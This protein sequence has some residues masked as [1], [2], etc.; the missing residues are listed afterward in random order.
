MVLKVVC[1]RCGEQFRLADSK[2]GKRF[3]CHDCG[4]VVEVPSE[5]AESITPLD[6]P[7][8]SV[9]PTV[10]PSPVIDVPL[11]PEKKKNSA[12]IWAIGLPVVTL[13]VGGGVVFLLSDSSPLH[14][15][16]KTSATP[17]SQE[18]G[19]DSPGEGAVN[20]AASGASQA[21]DE[22]PDPPA[23]PVAAEPEAAEPA[24]DQTASEL[25]DGPV[26]DD[27]VEQRA[28]TLSRQG[29]KARL[30]K[31][32]VEVFAL[33][34]EIRPMLT[35]KKEDRL[36]VRKERIARAEVKRRKTQLDADT[37]EEKDPDLT[38]VKH[39]QRVA[40]INRLNSG[41]G[42]PATVDYL[43]QRLT[44]EEEYPPV[45]RKL[46]A[47]LGLAGD[48]V[49][50]TALYEF[51]EKVIQQRKD[52]FPGAKVVRKKQL[53]KWAREIERITGGAMT[54]L[55]QPGVVVEGMEEQHAVVKKLLQTGTD[56]QKKLSAAVLARQIL[57]LAETKGV[58]AMEEIH[59]FRQ[60]H[61]DN[62]LLTD[63]GAD[64]TIAA[65][66]VGLAQVGHDVVA[67]AWDVY[68][69]DA[70]E[71]CRQAA[72]KT[73]ELGLMTGAATSPA[74]AVK[75][76]AL[77]RGGDAGMPLIERSQ[78]STELL[79]QSAG[80]AWDHAALKPLAKI[81][82]EDRGESIRNLASQAIVEILERTAAI[83]GIE[84]YPDLKQLG[85]KGGPVGA[86]AALAM[87]V[88]APLPRRADE[89]LK[90]RGQFRVIPPGRLVKT[91]AEIDP[92]GIQL[93]GPA[94]VVDVVD[95][96]TMHVKGRLPEAIATHEVEVIRFEGFPTS[97]LESGQRIDTPLFSVVGTRRYANAVDG[98][99][100]VKRAIPS[101]VYTRAMTYRQYAKYVPVQ[102]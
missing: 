18:T 33:L 9:V 61:V 13:L 37:L 2:A 45:Q 53:T 58:D 89:W 73:I 86:K 79:V 49:A 16:A 68:R 72:E 17:V 29:A 88:F 90:H 7:V 94:T 8:E 74:E 41:V 20:G 100:T 15:V 63:Q 71:E 55:L 51:R 12:L 50:L 28:T 46:C 84:A 60:D 54:R 1:G 5:T 6:V 59:S 99:K 87:K 22:T 57:L 36:A 42:Y 11:V 96:H 82:L 77:T 69:N 95:A 35:K 83:D 66:E 31:R 64:A 38:N 23:E 101:G 4:E 43:L 75:M 65:L 67:A 93:E 10:E 70:V 19:V 32:K 39:D 62:K 52:R 98:M 3:R 85:R 92:A 80:V 47:A 44:E 102:N 25:P 56:E 34:D 26:G 30:D 21:G 40:A 97:G 81:A 27:W 76:A 78:K 14:V 91:A 24:A 48:P